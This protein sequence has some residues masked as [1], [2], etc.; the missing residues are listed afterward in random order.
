MTDIPYRIALLRESVYLSGQFL[1]LRLHLKTV[2]LEERYALKQR[3][4][5]LQ[6]RIK[7]TRTG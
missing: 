3:A 7:D 4:E 1:L 5:R 6:E 2:S